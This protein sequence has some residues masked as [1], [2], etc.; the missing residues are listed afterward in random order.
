MAPPTRTHQR[1]VTELTVAIHEY[2]KKNHGICEVNVSP[3]AVFWDSLKDKTQNYVEPDI[4]A[5]CDNE[6]LDDKGCYGSPDWVIEVVSPSSSRLDYGRKQA[7]YLENAVKEYW[8][9]DAARRT[10]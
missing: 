8:G 3:F 9:V 10:V 5:I 4:S 7:L 2:I 1:I 6:K